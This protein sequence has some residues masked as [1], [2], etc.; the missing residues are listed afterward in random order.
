MRQG[1][2]D[3]HPGGDG[4]KKDE[5]GEHDPG[6]AFHRANITGPLQPAGGRQAGCSSRMRC[7]MTVVTPSPRIVTP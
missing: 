6:H 2:G 7:D 5:N 4:D 3:D 1:D